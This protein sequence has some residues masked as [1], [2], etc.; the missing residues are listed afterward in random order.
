M[1]IFHLTININ[2][3]FEVASFALALL[4]TLVLWWGLMSFNLKK[5][6]LG[7]LM[8]VILN[9]ASFWAFIQSYDIEITKTYIGFFQQFE[10][11]NL[12][13]AAINS[14]NKLLN[15][16]IYEDRKVY[17]TYNVMYAFAFSYVLMMLFLF[18]T[19]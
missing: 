1:S 12:I 19:E 5:E 9:G 16:G 13:I 15:S 18:I 3:V 17:R 14:I 7:V 8:F 11:V 4:A 6:I 2:R 10:D